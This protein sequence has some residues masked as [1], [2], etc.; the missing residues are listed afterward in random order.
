MT[1]AMH[2]PALAYGQ[3]GHAAESNSL[4]KLLSLLDAIVVNAPPEPSA[5]QRLD[6]EMT[7]W[8]VN[9]AAQTPWLN[10]FALAAV[11]Y[12]DS[13]VVK[14]VNPF[15]YVL[16]FLRWAIPDH[17]A[18]LAA[19]KVEEALVVYYGDPPQNRGMAAVKC[20]ST[21]QLHLQRFLQS[22]T[23]TQRERL[24]PFLLPA[25]VTSSRLVKLKNRVA[26]QVQTRRKEQ[27]FAVVRDLPGL[28]ALARQRYKWLADL[29]AQ[30]QR[31]AEAVKQQQVA[32][33]TEL[34]VKGFDPQQSLTFRLWDRRS[35]VEAHAAAYS[36]K[37]LYDVKQIRRTSAPPLFLQLVGDI[38]EPGWFLRAIALGLFHT[39]PRTAE[40]KRY[41][42][43]WRIQF[44]QCA[45]MGLL[46]P[47]PFVGRVLSSAERSARGSPDDSR[48]L[49]C[50]E[51]L[52]A[53]TAVGLFVL[54]SLVQTGMRIGELMQLTLDHECLEMGTLPQFDDPTHSWSEGAKQIYWRLYPKGSQTRARYWVTPQMLEAML[55]LLDMHQRQHGS[56]ALKAVSAGH[57]RQFSHARR[58]AGKHR[59][60]LQWAGRHMVVA[61]VY[62]CLSFLLLENPC[63]DQQ[64]QPVR[65]S[66]HVLRHGVA[67]WL[68]TQGIPLEEIM[69]LLKHVNITV[70]DYY[71]KLS[72]QDLHHKLGPA[73]TMLAGLAEADPASIRTAAD[74]QQVA[75]E[76]LKRYGALR[77]TP[78]GRCAV[79]TPCEVQF[80]CAGCPYYIPDPSRRHEVQEK[81]AGHAQAVKLFGQLGDYLQADVQQAH[82]R[83]WE[84]IA[85]EMDMLAAVELSVPS[86][87]SMLPGIGQDELGQQLLSLLLPGGEQLD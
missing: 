31:V 69:L 84:R 30:V 76:A 27:A 78:G 68:R 20:Y 1:T 8:L 83:N 12:A 34:T 35:W 87:E 49:F 55:L 29:D 21:L 53:G 14:Q 65:I 47:R 11:I 80:K 61:M 56:Q 45:Q 44:P 85:Q 82:R 46:H 41:I 75:Q 25:L 5:W 36:R 62:K 16:S 38:P 4:Q 26:A 19:L 42:H 13:G 23:P 72:P 81:I 70:T 32:L 52:L 77:Q 57:S 48:V 37:T 58:F 3:A 24:Q 64:G 22:L 39:G 9:T 51:P 2:A 17:Y 7:V 63:R 71:S 54:V 73:L 66:P 6:D 67:G 18:N 74:I 40:A 15:G 59:F 28:V 60:V 10:H 79:F 86:I 33:P 43:A 50:V